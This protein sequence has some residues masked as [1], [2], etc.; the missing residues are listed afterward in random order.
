M[1]LITTDLFG[2]ERDKVQTSIDR[3]RTFCPPEGYFVAFSGGKD[4]VVIK[5][6]CDM[7]G[8]KYDAH[9]N[10]TT[11]DPPE[12]VRFIRAN[13]PDVI[14]DRPERSMRQLIIEKQIPPMRHMRYCCEYLKEAHGDGRVTM[15]G[16]R[17]AESRNRKKNQGLVTIMDNRN[18]NIAKAA[19]EEAGANFTRTVRGGLS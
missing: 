15:T 9:Y 5:A 17:W 10:V 6:L 13:H 4:S 18:G 14:F 12:L 16:V 19:A 7:A 8:V 11:V 2:N 1:A 3:I